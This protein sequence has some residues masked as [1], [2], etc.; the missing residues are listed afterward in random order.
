[1]TTTEISRSVLT[2][3]PDFATI[4][5]WIK[6]GSSVL[7]LGCGDGTLLHYLGNKL[8][9]RGYGVEISAHNILACMQKG[10]NVI[11]S[12]LESGLSGFE[13]A[14]FDYVILSQ[15]LQAM[16]NTENI[17]QEILRVGK[18]GIVSFPNFGYWKNRLQVAA[19]H[20]PVSSN[21]PYQWYD[22][23]NI[24]L[25]TLHDFEQLCQKHKVNILERRVMNHD[26]KVAFFP[27]LFGIL[28]F[29]RFGHAA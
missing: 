28:A 5:A 2:L 19:G 7:D 8:D 13:N 10:I 16:K 15:T 17:I 27:N 20:M 1:M 21:L 11:H 12:D 29:Y 6:P 25:C 22:T 18:E 4:A 3:R 9:V 24:H 14:S 26:K 23:P